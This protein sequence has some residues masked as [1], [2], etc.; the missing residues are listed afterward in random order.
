[1][2]IEHLIRTVRI[3]QLTVMGRQLP[4]IVV[5]ALSLLIVHGSA[6]TIRKRQTKTARAIESGPLNTAVLLENSGPVVLQCRVPAATA[7]QTRVQWIEFGT[8]PT[9]DLISDGNVLIP[10][11]P[12]YLRY[13][14]DLTNP[15][16]F[17]LVISPLIAA[18]GAYY[19]C[20]DF[21]SAPPDQVA[22]GA[23]LV[24]V[25]A[26]PNC[27]TTIQSSIVI[28]GDYHTIECIMYFRASAG[29]EPLI[30]WTGPEPFLQASA[31]TNISVWSGI[32][33]TVSRSMDA[34]S[35]T[36]ITNFTQKGFDSPDSATNVPTLQFAYRSPQLL[37]N[38]GPKNMYITPDFPDYDVGTA[39]T[40]FADA[41]P[42]ATIYWQN[43]DTSEV[44]SSPTFVIRA[45]L[46]GENRMRCHAEN[47]I[48]GQLYFNDY[49]V[50]ITVK[51]IPTTPSPG[52]S[53]TTTTPPAEAFCSDLTGRW[54]ATNPRAS[55]CLWVDAS[56]NGVVSGLLQNDTETYWLDIYGRVQLNTWDQ[57]GFS[58]IS[59]GTIG[60]TAFVL[61]C[62][63]CFGVETLTVSQIQRSDTSVGTCGSP[64]V[65]HI[66]P[67]FIFNRVATTPPCNAPPPTF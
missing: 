49:F 22:L 15:G 23:Q 16:Q 48:N 32:S 38:W 11:H 13:N 42:A 65:T 41:F 67:E 12:N 60:V 24:V 31:V 46:V 8:R 61:E 4:I 6:R 3:S 35:Y 50:V 28:E 29:V 40:C 39:I 27:T 14:L 47:Y 56:Q 57:G 53:T 54:Q 19:V 33:F 66:L 10:G 1:L 51:P 45:D 25:E 2:D 9:G 7:D 43:L 55:L 36:S 17:D 62:K 21:N 34:L 30:T 58:T 63:A 44:W 64:G 26:P 37:V 18:D 5:L 52:P 59:P 20:R